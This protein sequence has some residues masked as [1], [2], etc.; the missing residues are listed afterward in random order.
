[1][2]STRRPWTRD[3]AML[4]FRLYCEIPFGQMH[5]GNPA[6]VR[7][8]TRIG[9]TPSAVALKLVNFAHLD[10]ALQRRGIRGMS[11]VSQQDREIA[12]AFVHDW[13]ASV[14][15]T[16]V[17][18]T[19]DAEDELPSD[20]PTEVL[21]QTR[22]RLTQ[23]F[24]RRAVLS[25]YDNQCCACGIAV[26]SLL[27]ASHIKPWAVD[28]TTRSSPRNGLA[29]CALHDRAFDRGLITVLPTLAISVSPKLDVANPVSVLKAAFVELDGQSIRT[30]SRF[31]PE[32]SCLEYHNQNVFMR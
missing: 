30:P 16:A 1:M 11:N 3:E 10:P 5:R 31:L 12:H 7:M 29:L 21:V 24:F 4:V 27:T 2:D 23:G 14:Q 32:S 8:A 18:S 9:R 26:P 20:V 19:S 6:V 22:A 25:A 15:N 17:A 13:E 28:A